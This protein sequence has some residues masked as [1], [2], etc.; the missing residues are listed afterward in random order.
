M[1]VP[2]QKGKRHFEKSVKK[3][4]PLFISDAFNTTY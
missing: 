1:L 2:S 3:K 4:A